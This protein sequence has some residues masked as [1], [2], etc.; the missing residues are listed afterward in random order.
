MGRL[1]WDTSRV[2]DWKGFRIPC[3]TG[4]RLNFAASSFEGQTAGVRF[5]STSRLMLKYL[6]APFRQPV[7]HTI[8]P[9]FI[10]RGVGRM[11]QQYVHD[12]STFLEVGCGSMLL[13]KYLPKYCVYNAI[14]M[15]VSQFVLESVVLR[16]PQVNF[17]LALATD[18]PLPDAS[19]DVVAAT[20]VFEHIPPIDAALR[21]IRRILRPNGVLVCSIPNNYFFKYRVVGENTDHVNKWKFDEF[22]RVVEAAGFST[23][24]SFRR[25]V[26]VPIPIP[27]MQNFYLPFRPRREFFT[28]NFFYAFRACQ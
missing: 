2:V 27:G 26:W 12:D 21:E 4:L 5:D 16:E 3:A 8:G 23:E 20:E 19:V 11:L 25:G 22:P 14:E 1:D 7:L 17:A 9:G 24:V 6:L 10:L 15:S 18:I 28:S 13:R